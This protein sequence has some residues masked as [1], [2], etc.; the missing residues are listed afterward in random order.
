MNGDRGSEGVVAELQG[1]DGAFS[2][3]ELLLQRI[4]SRLDF[5]Q[6]RASTVAGESVCVLEPGCWNRLGGPDFFDAKFDIGD[7]RVSGDVEVHLRAAD[8]ESHRHTENMAYSRVALHVVLFPTLAKTTRGWDG[9]EIPILVLLPLLNRSLEEYAED[10]AVERLADHPLTKARDALLALPITSQREM[11][12][13]AA[14]E[15]WERKQ[16]LAALKIDHLGWREA[17]HHTALEILGY[18]FNRAAMVRIAE[19]WP[20]TSWREIDQREL[21]HRAYASEAGHWRLQAIRPANLPLTRLK[22]YA[23]WIALEPDWPQKLAEFADRLPQ[24]ANKEL[25][26]S[27]FRRVSRGSEITERLTST[28]VRGAVGGS[29]LQTLL[30][31]GFWPLLAAREPARARVCE[32]FW[33]H[34]QIGDVPDNLREIGQTLAAADFR[35]R[36]FAH[37]IAQGLLSWCARPAKTH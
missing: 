10:E 27:R 32:A 29:R 16:M 21:V 35:L 24:F 28:V 3:A 2:F 1:L 6:T 4:W 20:L 37:G 12:T 14:K 33:F 31:D 15:R 30:G 8:W 11:L 36:P 5:D 34:G 22:Q 18:R 9:G 25:E 26:T 7:R 23:R 19:R 13:C 17:C